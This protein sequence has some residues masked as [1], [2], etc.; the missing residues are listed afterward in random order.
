MAPS[1]NAPSPE[2]FR[3]FREDLPQTPPKF[4]PPRREIQKPKKRSTRIPDFVQFVFRIRVHPPNNILDNP[5][6]HI[7]RIVLLVEIKRA[8]QFCEL[9]YFTNVLDQTDQQ[10]RRTFVSFPEVHTLGL[11][12]A[13][14]DCWTYREYDRRNMV[15]SPSPSEQKDPT[16]RESFRD[17]MSPST[18]FDGVNQHFGRKGFARLQE[19]ASDNALRAIHLRLKFL[20]ST[21]FAHN[22][23]CCLYCD[24]HSIELIIEFGPQGNGLIIFHPE[25][26]PDFQSY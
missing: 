7:K 17:C 15:S 4:S 10:A 23:E 3:G 8:V 9:W 16:Y 6:I 21:M 25:A 13:L 18:I 14:G 11:I 19:P 5:P 24:P 20:C 2:V 22:C 12:V 26:S 1:R